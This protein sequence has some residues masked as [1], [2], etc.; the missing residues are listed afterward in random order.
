MKRLSQLALFA[1]LGQVVLLASVWFLPLV[2]EHGLI[3][4]NISE[5]VLG[6]WGFFQTLAFVLSGLGVI[7]LSSAIRR[8]TAERR[9]LSSVHCS[10]PSTV[11]GLWSPPSSP[12]T[13]STA[14]LMSGLSR[15]PAGFTA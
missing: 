10:S 13:E 11:R 3:G 4:D 6:R 9:G 12:P 7:G 14:R 5:L 1:L 15:R 8:H 2:S